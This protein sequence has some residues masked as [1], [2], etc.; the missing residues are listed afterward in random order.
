MNQTSQSKNPFKSNVVANKN[1]GVQ[2]R[3]CDGFGHIQSE[4]ANT[5]KKKA[6]N[7]SWSDGDSKD[8]QNEENDHIGNVAF[9]SICQIIFVL[10][11]KKRQIM[12]Q[13]K[14]LT[15]TTI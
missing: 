1:K 6:M 2:C 3:D 7:S 5:L 11:C 9:A 15:V 13:Q 8:S 10:L 4:C 12:L 14:L